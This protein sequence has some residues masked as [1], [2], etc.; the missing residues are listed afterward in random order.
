MDGGRPLGLTAVDADLVYD[1]S[2]L[3]GGAEVHVLQ[4]RMETEVG[5]NG[6]YY[7]PQCWRRTS[8]TGHLSHP[9]GHQCPATDRYTQV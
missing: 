9:K 1:A 8:W 3:D 4:K 7:S 6:G 5:A 2:V